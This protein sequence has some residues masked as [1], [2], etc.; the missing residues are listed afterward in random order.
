MLLLG[1]VIGISGHAQTPVPVPLQSATATFSQT[2]AADFFVQYMVDGLDENRGWQI[3]PMTSETQTAVFE[4]VSDIGSPEGTVL[5]F[6][7]VQTHI[8]PAVEQQ[9]TLGRFRFSVTSDNRDDFA[10]GAH[11]GGDVTANWTILQPVSFSSQNGATLTRLQDGS[12]LASGSSPPTDVYTVTA[13]TFLTNITGIR[14]EALTDPSLP[15]QGPGR[16][17]QNGN[18]CVTE[19]EVVGR[20]LHFQARIHPAVELCWDSHQGRTY[21]MVW[22]ADLEFQRWAVIASGIA[23]TGQ[24]I[25]I[26]DT[27]RPAPEGFYRII[28]E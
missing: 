5:I 2:E 7:L 8:S 23:G 12:I 14:L 15:H 27:T 28:E 11:T 9:H 21:S 22:A 10:D 17:P 18:F 3:Y 1:L 24:Q 13:L 16:Q 19:M 25:C 26:F 4:T 20:S 6:K